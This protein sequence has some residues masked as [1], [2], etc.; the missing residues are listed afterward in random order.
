MHCAA[1]QFA[2]RLSF[3]IMLLSW[4]NNILLLV[5]AALAPP[6][7]EIHIGG[8][9]N[10]VP[11]PNVVD[12]AQAQ[13][14]AAF[15]LAI[16]LINN[17]TD[18][19][20]DD[21]LPH[22]TLK[23]SIRPAADNWEAARSI[24]SLVDSS[25]GGQ[26]VIGVVNAL[27][28][29]TALFSEELFVNSAK[30]VLQVLSMVT[31][32]E[33]NDRELHPYSV[34]TRGLISN[35]AEGFQSLL[36][37]YF[38]AKKV[39]IVSSADTASGF[40]LQAFL[41]DAYCS[42]IE[43]LASVTLST[44]VKDFSAPIQEVLDVGGRYFVLL[45][46]SKATALFLEQAYAAGVFSDSAVILTTADVTSEIIPN[47]SPGT[48]VVAVLKNLFAFKLWAN[49]FQSKSEMFDQFES[50]WLTQPATTATPVAA[51]CN[52]ATDDDG[53]YFLY[54]DQGNASLCTGLTF[55]RDDLTT[56]SFLPLTYDAVLLLAH[57]VDTCIK[58]NL[59]YRVPTVLQDAMITHAVFDGASGPVSLK[60]G[61]ELFS[62][63]G[64]GNRLTGIRYFLLNFNVDEYNKGAYPMAVVGSWN[65][66]DGSYHDCGSTVMRGTVCVAPQFWDK[67]DQ[68]SSTPPDDMPP[69]IVLYVTTRDQGILFAFAAITLVIVLFF[70]AMVIIKRK[71]KVIKASQPALLLSI[72]FGG[73]LSVVRIMMGAMD[74]TDAVCSAEVWFGHTAFVVMVGSLF[75]KAWRVNCIVNT[76]T[77]KKVRFTTR[78]AMLI[79]F[80]LVG[81]ML[82]YLAIT[83]VVGQ[84][85]RSNQ[86]TLA[87]NQWTY[88]PHCSFQY[89]EFQTTLFAVEFIFLMYVFRVCWSIRNVP[90]TV[91][92][93][94]SIAAG[95]IV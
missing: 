36:C 75:V 53:T 56:N 30:K 17:K 57:G 82:V 73:L 31:S 70:S 59:D 63:D 2:L 71:D 6:H 20:F 33:F 81:S 32:P 18:G 24:E 79:L 26:E 12:V 11:Q 23:H 90:D 54:R 93:S 35:R 4:S 95:S 8:L 44:G 48:N 92:E 77:I 66:D 1:A 43:I 69:P 94:K 74:K 85:Y 21:I 88:E 10:I 41:D 47:F 5:T 65:G 83:Q 50:R 60:A 3:W 61:S 78:D 84:P 29:V 68:V 58:N 13:H 80:S 72:L 55:N 28:D 46:S 49:Y 45:S 67:T 22:T 39:V 52:N 37:T 14:Q 15:L 19:L 86:T 76:K 64:R 62:F 40:K 38:K 51:V 9:F 89:A 7:V 27:T 34:R 91:N 16:K 25:F 42:D 87:K